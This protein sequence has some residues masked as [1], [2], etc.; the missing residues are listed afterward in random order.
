M[1]YKRAKQSPFKTARFIQICDG[2][3]RGGDLDEKGHIL[4]S[5]SKAERRGN[6]DIEGP[7]QQNKEVKMSMPNH[8]L[9]QGKGSSLCHQTDLSWNYQVC[10]FFTV[11]DLGQLTIL[12]WDSFSSFIIRGSSPC[13]N[14]IHKTGLKIIEPI[15]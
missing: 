12:L 14:F 4:T 11:W 13:P 1:G 7:R 15:Y 2:L 9:E 3:G 5:R 10:H 6:G 8:F